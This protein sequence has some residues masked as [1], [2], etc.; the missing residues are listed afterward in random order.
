MLQEGAVPAD[1]ALI[2][3]EDLLTKDV[4]AL[5][6]MVLEKRGGGGGNGG[7]GSAPEPP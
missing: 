7:G 3:P 6:Q 4:S 5:R 2:Q 1:F